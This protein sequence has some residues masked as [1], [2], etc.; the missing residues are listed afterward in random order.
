MNLIDNYKVEEIRTIKDIKDIFQK[1]E[2][3]GD[4]WLFLSTEGNHGTRLNLD[5]LESILRDENELT[6]SINGR[7]WLTVLI[8]YPQRVS[9]QTGISRIIPLLKYGELLIDLD[10]IPWLRK[11]VKK[12]LKEVE[13]SQYGNI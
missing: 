9:A 7:Y 5:D 8:V 3:E 1:E 13:K 11:T 4:A 6:A 2:S 12:T 10:D